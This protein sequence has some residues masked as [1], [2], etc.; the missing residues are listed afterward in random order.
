[1]PGFSAIAR[2]YHL[3]FPAREAQLSFLTALAGPPP[4]RIFDVA[5]GT[6]E[7]AAALYARGYDCYGIDLDPAMHARARE[8]HP[9][10]V[11]RERLLQG[12][13]LELTEL[14]RGP[15]R[16]A[17]CIGNSLPQLGGDAQVREAVRQMWDLTRPD[18]GVALQVVNFDRVLREGGAR[19]AAQPWTLPTLHAITENGGDI[20][21]ERSYD[22]REAPGRVLFQTRLTH[23]G[24]VAEGE[25]ALLCLARER[26]AAVLPP[27][28]R[29]EWY[30]DFAN[31][32]W[33][34]D[35][36]ATVCVLR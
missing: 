1:M 17:Y 36:A 5:S 13:M 7:Y 19:E 11:G 20:A 32:P 24:G 6:G 35:S 23:P 31:A 29:V 26:L 9:E 34:A 10:L 27:Q 28:A 4:A 14:V 15:A 3:L 16:L 22:L 30:G 18:G 8:R 21:L 12:D 2:Y 33:S 25:T